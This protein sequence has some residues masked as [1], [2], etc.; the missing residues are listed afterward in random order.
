MFPSTI[1]QAL[2]T[3]LALAVAQCGYAV[4]TVDGHL[5]A[6]YGAPLA[7]QSVNTE[8]GDSAGGLGIGGE[9]DAGYAAIQNGRLFIMLTGNIENNFNHANVFLDSKPGG[10]NVLSPVPQYDSDFGMGSTSPNLGGLTF[11]DG[12]EADYHVFGRVG[13]ELGN[14][15][16]V[17]IV[18]RAGGGSAAVNG[19]GAL[20]SSGGGTGVQSGTVGPADLGRAGNGTRSLTPF[21]TSPL[22]FAWDNSNSAGVVAGTGAADPVAAAAVTTGWEF[23]I[24]LADIGNPQSG[25]V[26]KIHA[27]YG[28][29]TN[30]YHSNQILS[31]LSAPQGNLGGDGSGNF[32][33]DL[34]G[35]DFNNWAGD[36][37]FA[38]LVPS[39]AGDYDADGDVDQDDFDE[40]VSAYG[41]TVGVPGSG[42]DG[43]ADGFVDAADYTVWRDN[44]QD[45]LAGV[46]EPGAMLLLLCGLVCSAR[47]RS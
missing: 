27:A 18:D 29:D 34:S 36:Q 25:D 33:G 40:W 19:N 35:I 26:I 31:G 3:A 11:D 14:T 23:S 24:A 32:T 21:L 37:Y 12:F 10:E 39:I 1:G 16:E 46:P 41:T 28:N 42:A 2:S 4:I 43:N 13:P 6:G 9:L 45:P 15:F 20:A 17:D 8:F 38:S 47:Q 5:D 44:L 22:D 7:V 30:S